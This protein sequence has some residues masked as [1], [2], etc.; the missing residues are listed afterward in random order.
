M[1]HLIQPFINAGGSP[2]AQ[3]MYQ[4][5][6]HSFDFIHNAFLPF[7]YPKR[8]FN[9]LHLRD[10]LTSMVCRCVEVERVHS[11]LPIFLEIWTD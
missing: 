6:R 2:S 1:A 9:N 11:R 8:A 10:H 4:S 7:G 3:E 5:T